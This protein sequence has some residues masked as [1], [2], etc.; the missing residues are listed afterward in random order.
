MAVTFDAEQRAELAVRMTQTILDD[1]AF[2]FASHLKMSIVCQEGV[3]GLAAHPS[4][5]Y[6]I[7]VDLDKEG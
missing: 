6:E 2:V 1:S 3:S 5:Y 4:D 7:T